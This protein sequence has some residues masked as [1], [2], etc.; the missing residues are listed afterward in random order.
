MEATRPEVTTIIPTRDREDWWPRTLVSA[1][2]QKDV[3]AEIIVV[4][5]GSRTPVTTL[6]GTESR[7]RVRVIRH[8]V[9]QGPPSARNAGIAEA[10]GPWV[11]LLDDDDLWAPVKLRRQLEVAADTGADF[12]FSGGVAADRSGLPIYVMDPPEAD[13]HLYPALLGA[14][15]VPFTNSSLL[16]KTDLLKSLGGFD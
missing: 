2:G 15:V 1:L 5:D 6:L 11:A 4:D 9:P 14:C 8:D 10:R 7:Q 13:E 16:V 3:E 12:V